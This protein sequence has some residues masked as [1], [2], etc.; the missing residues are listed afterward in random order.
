MWTDPARLPDG[1]WQEVFNSDA[2]MFGGNN[3]GNGGLTLQV[4]GGVINA[5]IPA[6][7]FVVFEKVG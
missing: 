3:I 1:W 7:G 2:A 4:N 6:R 5:V